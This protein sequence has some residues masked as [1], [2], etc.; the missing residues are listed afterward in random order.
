MSGIVLA[1]NLFFELEKNPGGDID[2]EALMDEPFIVPESMP[3]NSLL[4]AFQENRRHMAIVVDEYGD[5]EG[6]VTLEDVLEEIVGEIVDESDRE[7]QEIWRHDDGS[8]EILATIDMRKVG[9]EIG[10]EWFADGETITAGGLLSEQLGR[11][12]V[13]GDTVDW[14]GYRF[15]VLSATRR[16]QNVSWC[17][18]SRP[19]RLNQI[20]EKPGPESVHTARQC[21]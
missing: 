20:P 19:M 9:E 15:T 11:I 5:V 21:R 10:R 13:T 8:L 18:R 14:D 12:P 6:I 3:L 7:L 4:R 1:K 17:P 16:R 2:W